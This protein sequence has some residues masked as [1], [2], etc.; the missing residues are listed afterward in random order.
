MVYALGWKTGEF[1]LAINYLAELDNKKM[2]KLRKK[3]R[4][5]NL[6]GR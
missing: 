1:S 6:D 2:E 5:K 4:E 3:I